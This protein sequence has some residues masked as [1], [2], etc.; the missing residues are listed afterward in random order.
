MSK[1]EQM[2]MFAD[3]DWKGRCAFVPDTKHRRCVMFPA[4]QVKEESGEFGLPTIDSLN[5]LVWEPVPGRPG[6][7]VAAKSPKLPA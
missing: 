7:R 5:L 2:V 6:F 1:R 3:R 4:G